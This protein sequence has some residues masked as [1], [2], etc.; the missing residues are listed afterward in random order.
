MNCQNIKNS[1]TIKNVDLLSEQEENELKNHLKDCHPCEKQSSKLAD[2]YK[3]LGQSESTD[4]NLDS[5]WEGIQSDIK[6]AEAYPPLFAEKPAGSNLVIALSCSYCHG[7]LPRAEAC[8]CASCLSPHHDDCFKTHGRCTSMGCEET[9]TVKP[10]LSQAPK[11]KSAR[12]RSNTGL[13]ALVVASP[14]LVVG[15]TAG[16]G[17]NRYQAAKEQAI[18]EQR[19]AEEDAIIR[20]NEREKNAPHITVFKNPP[21]MKDLINGPMKTTEVPPAANEAKIDIE[22]VDMD[23]KELVEQ[24]ANSA[25]YNILVS[26]EIAERVTI[27]LREIPWKQALNLVAKL[28]HC[29]LEEPTPNVLMLT[30][31][32]KVTIQFDQANIRT[33]LQLLAAYSGKNILI[34]QNVQGNV[35]VDFKD[36]RWDI[37]LAALVRVN[38]LYAQQ[39]NEIVIVSKSPFRKRWGP[40]LGENQK[41]TKGKKISLNKSATLTD[42]AKELSKVSD[43][44]IVVKSE[45]EEIYPV[46]LAGIPWNDALKILA[47]QSRREII[48]NDS[49]YALLPVKDNFFVAKNAPSALWCQTLG[50]LAEKNI[51]TQSTL[52]SLVSTGFHGVSAQA[53][54]AATAHKLGCKLEEK[55]GVLTI[56][57][58]RKGG[59]VKP[60]KPVKATEIDVGY[61]T[62]SLRLQGALR[63]HSKHFAIISGKSYNL[64]STLFDENDEELPIRVAEIQPNFVKLKVYDKGWDKASKVVKLSFPKD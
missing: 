55:S 56:Q 49:H 1:I 5:I 21:S 19:L 40:E 48:E 41:P 7:P 33:V 6:N 44:P 64:A 35:S 39:N 38:K 42:F 17:F 16:V 60:K 36:T 3:V 43:K 51:V 62:V 54:L 27:K 13:I 2:A 25:K 46:K 15:L 10:Q 58:S 32:P 24:I 8:Y 63:N 53:A 29:E 12:K 20:A 11:P 34:D 61:R 14:L 30:Q 31:P 57:S 59:I 45:G 37:A 4:S 50:A 26:P 18:M 9:H 52:S 47:R 23:L 28:T 22:V